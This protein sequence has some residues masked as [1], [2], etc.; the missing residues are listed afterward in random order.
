MTKT[1]KTGTPKYSVKRGAWL[2]GDS[3]TLYTFTGKVTGEKIVH[4]GGYPI[5]KIGPEATVTVATR[6]EAEA[7]WQN[8]LHS[9]WTVI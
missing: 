3:R 2:G 4:Y 8:P 7:L 9:G 6:D 1:K 5:F